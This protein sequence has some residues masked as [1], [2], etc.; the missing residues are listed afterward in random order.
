MTRPIMIRSRRRQG[1]VLVA[2]QAQDREDQAAA[3]LLQSS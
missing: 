1:R 2:G 3:L